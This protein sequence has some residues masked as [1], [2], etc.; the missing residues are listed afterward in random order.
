MKRAT[1]Y[2][3]QKKQG[4]YSEIERKFFMWWKTWC[5]D[6]SYALVRMNKDMLE[7]DLD[8]YKII[9]HLP[10]HLGGEQ[11]E[12]WYYAARHFAL[13][14][15]QWLR[16]GGERIKIPYELLVDILAVAIRATNERD[17]PVG[18]VSRKKGFEILEHILDNPEEDY[19]KGEG[20]DIFN[21]AY[22]VIQHLDDIREEVYEAVM[23][24]LSWIIL[25]EDN[26]TP[27]PKESPEH[28]AWVLHNYA[29]R[30]LRIVKDRGVYIFTPGE[31]V[32]GSSV[33]YMDKLARKAF[34][35]DECVFFTLLYKLWL[36][37]NE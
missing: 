23:S 33:S 6:K 29:R 24:A 20:N 15:G 28:L 32:E 9:R 5:E 37:L 26:E 14:Y 34:T 31:Y 4:S 13:I 12:S 17:Y 30:H 1:K 3:E 2:F 27:M 10:A 35:R 36:T 22:I 18:E 7:N 8:D 16:K 11:D 25:S 19:P 21:S